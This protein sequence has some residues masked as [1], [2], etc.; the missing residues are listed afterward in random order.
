MFTSWCIANR[1]FE[2]VPFEAPVALT[3][4][5]ILWTLSLDFSPGMLSC[6]ATTTTMVSWY[7]SRDFAKLVSGADDP[8]VDPRT[9]YR[10]ERLSRDRSLSL[11][12]RA[13]RRRSY[14][15]IRGHLIW[16][17]ASILIARNDRVD[18]TDSSSLLYSDIAMQILYKKHTSLCCSFHIM[19]I[20]RWIYF[21]R[22]VL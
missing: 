19:L 1:N 21:Y 4:I 16:L 14:I 20:L 8:G 5:H 15:Y 22:I 3:L 9:R 12:A 18:W 17:A 13:R 10:F 11:H 7:V 6:D 2:I